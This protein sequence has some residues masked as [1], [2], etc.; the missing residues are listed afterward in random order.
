VR[1][2]AG[3]RRPGHAHNAHHGRRPGAG[4]VSGGPSG[5]QRL[6][7]PRAFRG[8]ALLI[9]AF[10]LLGAAAAAAPTPT[11]P[12]S[13]ASPPHPPE[14]VVPL[15]CATTTKVL[16]VRLQPW[17]CVSRPT[18]H[19][20]SNHE[21]RPC[22]GLRRRVLACAPP[23]H[24]CRHHQQS[25]LATSPVRPITLHKLRASLR[26][27]SQSSFARVHR[28]RRMVS[29]SIPIL[30]IISYSLV[31]LSSLRRRAHERDIV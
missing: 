11:R 30:L 19:P 25:A 15:L 31:S 9:L 18:I 26:H 8:G 17:T 20:A 14:P 16:C 3:T 6:A 22:A 13:A 28:L 29:A 21:A 27:A 7:C 12:R 24:Y 23:C 10:L 4:G 1:R 2:R 5:L